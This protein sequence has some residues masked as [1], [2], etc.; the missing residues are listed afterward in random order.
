MK[1]KGFTLIEILVVIAL[2]GVLGV[3]LTNI[4][5]QVLRGQNKINTVNL[6][7]QNGQVILDQLSNEI[8]SAEKVICVEKNA[9]NNNGQADLK[10]TIVLFR[11]G[12]YTRFRF[13]PP[14]TSDPKRNG[15]IQKE[16]FTI[17]DIPEDVTDDNM[18]CTR[19]VNIVSPP[20]YLTY[21]TNSISLNYDGTS[22][23]FKPKSQAGFPDLVE[24]K[25]R[26]S[27]DIK[28]KIAE[29]TVADEGVLFTTAVSVK[30]GK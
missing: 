9:F 13:V 25:F 20:S 21:N 27:Q 29:S 2:L 19:S 22:P 26:G 8:R 12:N 3:I 11:N 6:V 5:S 23:I 17:S 16:I 28:S 1:N 15:Y 24:I 14:V 18:L 10:D 7:K 30:G 4:L